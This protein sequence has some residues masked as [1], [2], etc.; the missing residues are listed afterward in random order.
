V[1]KI[2]V[3]SELERIDADVYMDS[4]LVNDKPYEVEPCF[5]GDQVE[6]EEESSADAAG[7]GPEAAPAGGLA[8]TEADEASEDDLLSEYLAK[9]L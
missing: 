7:P 3:K 9:I 1:G 2:F 4:A 6:E 8:A 5:V